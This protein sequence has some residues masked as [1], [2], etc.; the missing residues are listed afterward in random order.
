MPRRATACRPPATPASMPAK[1]KAASRVSVVL[2]PAAAAPRSLS[3][4]AE[5]DR[6]ARAALRLRTMYT[7]ATT[8]TTASAYSQRSLDSSSTPQSSGR[9]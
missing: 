6:P 7:P 9:S 3:R 1:M 8:R 5:I 4:V 2:M